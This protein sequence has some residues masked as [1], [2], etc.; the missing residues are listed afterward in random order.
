MTTM[1]E[2][3][4]ILANLAQLKDENSH[5]TSES[6]KERDVKRGL[7][8][9]S[10][11]GVLVGLTQIGDVQGYN[12]VDGKLI[13][14]KGRLLYRGYDLE[15]LVSN[16]HKEDR[17]GFEEVIY[18]LLSG[19]LPNRDELTD[20]SGYLNTQIALTAKEKM[21]LISNW[22]N[23]IMNILSRTVLH[24]Y[25]RDT[26]AE[27]QSYENILRQ[28][29]DLIARF[30]TII[31]YGYMA[32]HHN[33]SSK[34]LSIRH[35][36]KNV[37]QAENMLYMLKGKGR[38]TDL[39]VKLLDLMLMIH[40]EHGGGNNS[41]FTAR[42]TASSGTD[43][44]SV[45]SSALASLKGPLHGGAARFCAEM[46][47]YLKKNVKDWT[48]D[49]EVE[50]ALQNLLDKKG[51]DKSGKIYGIGHAVYTKSDPRAN[52]LSERARELAI[53]K[54][55]EKEYN[56]YKKVES[57]AI[58]LLEKRNNKTISTNVDF[59]SGFVYSCLHIPIELYTALFATARVAGW[60][61]HRMEELYSTQKRIIRPAYSNISEYR[62]V[63][64]LEK[65]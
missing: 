62:E 54:G 61:A 64:P 56:F 27:D 41:T 8:M 33:I 39:E 2:Q 28:C 50:Q 22:G 10:G 5:F 43:T 24:M 63:T 21:G 55:R 13:P 53:E 20:F 37:S 7:R 23:N 14:M 29:L 48:S 26:N 12:E 9:A 34:N 15:S 51:F 45:I 59:F 3:K 6:Y 16:V 32:K 40:A 42:V 1:E 19:R 57:I 65:R 44:Y 18:L 49:S 4:K 58:K 46:M 47:A 52:L 30:P 38:Y 17:C 36:L 11:R 60:C 35:P 25:T 31:C